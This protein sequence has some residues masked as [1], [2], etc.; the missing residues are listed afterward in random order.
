LDDTV[1][2]VAPAG[3]AWTST[4]RGAITP[5]NTIDRSL[6]VDHGQSPTRSRWLNRPLRGKFLRLIK[7]IACLLDRYRFETLRPQLKG[8]DLERILA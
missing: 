2:L 5:G 8:S 4:W 3:A 6:P 1:I 7:S